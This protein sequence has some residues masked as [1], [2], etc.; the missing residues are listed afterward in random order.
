MWERGSEGGQ[1]YTLESFTPETESC[2]TQ[3]VVCSLYVL[4]FFNC[5]IGDKQATW[6]GLLIA[7]IL[8]K[9]SRLNACFYPRNLTKMRVRRNGMEEATTEGERRQDYM[10]RWKTNG[11]GKLIH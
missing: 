10:C 8:V 1:V 11:R 7:V 6:R 9:Y 5:K 3:Q 2:L 4:S